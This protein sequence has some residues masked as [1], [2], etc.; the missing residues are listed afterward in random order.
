MALIGKSYKW[1]KACIIQS[2]EKQKK[3]K[4]RTQTWPRTEQ[5]LGETG[6]NSSNCITELPITVLMH[7]RSHTF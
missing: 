4:Q 2:E 7:R 5:C 1:S 3:R 6:K